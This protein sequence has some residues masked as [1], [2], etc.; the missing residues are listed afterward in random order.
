[1]VIRF[2]LSGLKQGRWYE[3]VA[4]FALGGASTVLAGIIADAFGPEAGGL[5]LAFPAIFCASASLIEKHERQ[6]KR[7]K[8]LQG[9]VRGR[10]A[11]ALDADGAGW[12]SAA[13][14]AFA[15][16]VYFSASVLSF[17]VCVA[18]AIISWAA[19]AALMWL[20]RRHLRMRRTRRPIT[21]RVD[22]P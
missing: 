4:R 12:G 7:D 18:T 15:A 19:V 1:V 17:F 14:L 6:R 3:Y 22:L 11:A 9:K 20:L 21:A 16:A 8:A 2:Q 13:L 10:Q 5:F